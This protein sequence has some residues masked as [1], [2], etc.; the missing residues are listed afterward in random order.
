MATPYVLALATFAGRA[1]MHAFVMSQASSLPN[2]YTH[3]LAPYHSHHATFY[4]TEA[5]WRFISDEP[6]H[7]SSILLYACLATIALQLIGVYIAGE[8]AKR[9][10][11]PQ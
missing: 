8:I 2:P 6:L 4:F 11:Q 10:E 9:C 5:Q 3:Q 1:I 7:W